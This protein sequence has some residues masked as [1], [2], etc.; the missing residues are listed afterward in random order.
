MSHP[1]LDQT[2][3]ALVAALAASARG[4][5]RDGVFALWLVARAALGAAAPTVTPER[6]AERLRAVGA[7]VRTLSPA[8]AL[9]RGVAAALADLAAARGAAP[10]IALAHLAA[11]AAESGLGAAAAALQAAARSAR[12]AA[13][14][15]A[16]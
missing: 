15:P 2:D 13:A 5:E 6:H 3:R 10:A 14:E 9:R 8:A 16:R 7:R 1:A 11:P 12:P 4:P